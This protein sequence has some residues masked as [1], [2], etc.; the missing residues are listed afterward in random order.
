[1]KKKLP[2]IALLL[3]LSVTLTACTVADIPVIGKL[4]SRGSGQPTGPVTLNVW[5]LWE[6][7]AVMQKLID[8]YQTEHPNVTIKYDDRSIM[9][10]DDYKDRVFNSATQN[11]IDADII[12]V[13]NSWV[14]KLKEVLVPAPNDV[15][16][17]DTFSSTFYPAATQSAVIDGAAYAVPLY[18]DGLALVY[19]K[20]HFEEIGQK[21]PPTV[22]EEFRRL[23]LQLTDRT[24]PTSNPL[25]RAGAAIGTSTNIDFFSDILGLMWSQANV[26]IP[27][28]LD[29]RAAQDA[30]TYYTNFVKEDE[31]WSTSMPEATTAFANEQV[32][33]IFAPSWIVGELIKARPNLEIG[34][35]PV[36]Q[37]IVSQPVGWASF[38]MEGVLK[39]S[40][41]PQVAWDFLNFISQE[42]QQ[43]D[44]FNE[45]ASARRLGSPYARVSLA[46]QIKEDPYLGAYVKDAPTARTAVMT[47]RSGNKTQVDLLKVAVSEVLAGAKSADA[48]KKMIGK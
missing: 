38:W 21:E 14:P 27:N 22:W 32:S 2:F 39:S 9:K 43:L 33:M 11:T 37:A 45:S 44:Y 10:P 34:V 17:A 48:L 41:N 46:T 18:Y 8:K 35:A 6:D 31:V 29:S 42:Q 25:V 28:E 4:L 16:S 20:K 19:N 36:P 3:V 40:K 13:H 12:M 26:G 30:L 15:L 7:P 1:M 24:G 47:A 5:G 23:A